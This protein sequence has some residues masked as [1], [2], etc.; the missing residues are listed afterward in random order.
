M[1]NLIGADH[2]FNDC[3]VVR[4]W[5]IVLDANYIHG[6][7]VFVKFEDYEDA[8]RIIEKCPAVAF[9]ELFK[10]SILDHLL[11]MNRHLVIYDNEHITDVIIDF[12]ESFKSMIGEEKLI[13]FAY[14]TA[15]YMKGL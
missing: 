12:S 6:V 1:R 4:E 10:A 7:H 15:S 13:N 14:K 2:I 3:G 5:S 9:E 8:K 11:A